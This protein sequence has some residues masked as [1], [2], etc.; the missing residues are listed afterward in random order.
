MTD[1]RYLERTETLTGTGRV[2]DNQGEIALVG[3]RVEVFQEKIECRT[4][5]GVTTVD[6]LK[7]IRGTIDAGSTSIYSLMDR[8]LTLVFED[9]RRMDFIVANANIA[10]NTGTI[11]NAGCAGIY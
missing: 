4:G 6:G 8:T 9:G 10:A 5:S 7:D 1:R 11:A 2:C 3:Y